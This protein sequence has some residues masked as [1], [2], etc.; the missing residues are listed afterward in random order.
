MG[1]LA[2]V[3]VRGSDVA[4]ARDV[5]RA[6]FSEVERLLNA[7]DKATEICTLAS[8]DDDHPCRPRSW[9]VHMNLESIWLAT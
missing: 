3:R 8:L 1:T 5:V 6:A 7:H 4:E 9:R 2:S